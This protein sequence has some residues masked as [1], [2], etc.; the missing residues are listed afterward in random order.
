MRWKLDSL[1]SSFH[2]AAGEDHLLWRVVAEFDGV[3]PWG[4]DGRLE[5]CFFADGVKDLASVIVD[6]LNDAVFFQSGKF[7][8]DFAAIVIVH[9]DG[10]RPAGELGFVS[11]GYFGK[12]GPTF[13]GGG[14]IF[15][16]R[17]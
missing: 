8:V 14:V 5:A 17:I 9:F 7:G 2:L 15:F 12:T 3:F 13:E 4:V 1:K 11:V 16:C 10:D 6:N